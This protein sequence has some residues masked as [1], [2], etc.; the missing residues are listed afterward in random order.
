MTKNNIQPYRKFLRYVI[1]ALF[2]LIPFL[3]VE[4]DSVFR[5][6]IP[7]LNLY[8]FGSVISI[9]NF[10][11]VLLITFVLTFAFIVMT[12]IFGRI[13]CGW[14]C[15]QTVITELTWFMQKIKKSSL[16]SK[17]LYHMAVLAFSTAIS[18]CLVW[19]FVSPYEFFER[20][21]AFSTGSVINGFIISLTVITYLNFAFM[22]QKF[23]KY[24]CPYSKFQSVMF[25][26]NTLV[27]QM[28]PETKEDCIKCLAC[29]K[30]C[31][32][33]IDIR[34]GLNS[35]CIACARCV[36][37]CRAVMKKKDKHTLIDYIFGNENKINP[38]RPT[39]LITGAVFLIFLSAFIYYVAAAKAFEFEA[40]P[41]SKFV[42][43]VSQS[44]FVN[45][46]EIK[47]SN[48]TRSIL[49]VEVNLEGVEGYS[50]SP[51]T[52]FKVEPN[53]STKEIIYLSLPE[54]LF[55]KKA[56]MSLKLRAAADD[57]KN[58]I[59]VSEISFRRPIRRI[60]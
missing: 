36:D 55:E 30:T 23:C 18:A 6:D 19:Y 49:N 15:P 20:L 41:N 21:A 24:M 32:T 10:F 42:P 14:L 47:F 57:E 8:F 31:P 45:S 3:K 7:S 44:G 53:S 46:Y 26:K 13:W 39:V 11:V 5:F 56:I 28:I 1:I 51:Q 59:S 58:T 12:Q 9:E 40:F 60:K 29:V 54:T 17:V 2:F 35:A 27:V 34:E 43:R 52:V 22:R 50:I 25:D 33:D 37:A 16:F 48:K 38:F 4:D